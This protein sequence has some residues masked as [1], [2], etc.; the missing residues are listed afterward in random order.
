M[1]CDFVIHALRVARLVIIQLALHFR[2]EVLV[3]LDHCRH[4]VE[5]VHAQTILHT[6]SFW[7]G[8][9][10]VSEVMRDS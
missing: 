3:E 8:V 9:P 2:V 5:E 4:D 10:L 1:S 7:V 6:Q